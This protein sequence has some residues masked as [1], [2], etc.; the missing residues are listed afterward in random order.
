MEMVGGR[1]SAKS[2]KSL[3]IA[4]VWR[5]PIPGAMTMI[6]FEHDDKGRVRA[7]LDAG[8]DGAA[9]MVGRWSADEASARESLE[10][11]L[12]AQFWGS[13]PA[14]TFEVVGTACVILLAVASLS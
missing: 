2:G 5:A 11:S 13:L 8:D 12:R 9:L 4:P 3:S 10:V 7:I 6:Q 1:A 14:M